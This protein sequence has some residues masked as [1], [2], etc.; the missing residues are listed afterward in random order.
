MHTF[1]NRL[2]NLF[3]FT[4]I[5]FAVL[6]IGVFLSTYFKQYHETLRTTANKSIIKHMI[7]FLITRVNSL[8][9]VVLWDKI[10]QRGDNA[11]INMH[12]MATKYNF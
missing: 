5:V 2:N 6:T 8:N 1:I 7:D 11:R 12:D 4:V 3:A 10:I 9:Q